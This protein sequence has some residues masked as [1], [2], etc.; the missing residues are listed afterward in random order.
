MTDKKKTISLL[1]ETKHNETKASFR[2]LL[3]H[4]ARKYIR[5]ILQPLGP[6]FSAY[7]ST[8]DKSTK[9]TQST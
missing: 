4:P 7:T 2:S 9:A 5:P 1:K 3:C 6:Y 8:Y